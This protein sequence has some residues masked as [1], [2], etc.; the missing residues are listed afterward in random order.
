M[1]H[2][3]IQQ[4]TNKQKIGN[5]QQVQQSAENIKSVAH[6]TNKRNKNNNK[7]HQKLTSLVAISQIYPPATTKSIH[8]KK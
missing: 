5:G 7:K 2:I 8:T 3:V 4:E 1:L 6:A